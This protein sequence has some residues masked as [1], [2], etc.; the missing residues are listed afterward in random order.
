M[1]TSLDK[2]PRTEEHPSADELA[3]FAQGR[4]GPEAM[5]SVERHVATC[6][7][8]CEQLAAVPDDTLI[9]LAREAATHGVRSADTQATARPKADPRAIPPELADHP[10]Y[11]VLGL[12]GLGGMGA[13]YKAQHRL[14]ERLVALKVISPKLLA[15]PKALERFR[16]EFRAVAKLS[17]PNV[18]AAHDADQAGDLHFLVMEFVEGLSLDRLVAQTGQLQPAQACNL[19]KQAALGLAH[20]HERGLVHRDI[21]PQNLMVTRRGQLKILDCGLARIASH[22]ADEPAGENAAPRQSDATAEGTILGTPDYI[23]PEQIANP[24][25]ADIRA[26]IYSLGCTLYF[27]LTGQTLFPKGTA[28]DKLA[29]HAREAPRPIAELR[30]GVPTE[31]VRVLDRMLA[32]NPAERFQTPAEVAKALA[33]LAKG[34][35]AEPLS[36][37]VNPI[38]GKISTAPTRDMPALDAGTPVIPLPA[39]D[40]FA[41]LPP[42]TAPVIAPVNRKSSSWLDKFDQHFASLRSVTGIRLAAFLVALPLIAGL[43]AVPLAFTFLPSPDEND[44]ANVI[45]PPAP[46]SSA[47]ALPGNNSNGVFSPPAFPPAAVPPAAFPP[48]TSTTVASTLPRKVLLVVPSRGLW[49]PDYANVKF[50]FTKLGIPVK[51]ASTS[52]AKCGLHTESPAGTLYPEMRLDLVRSR[53]FG[54][55]VFAGFDTSEFHPDGEAGTVTRRLLQEFKDDGKLIASICVG[56]RVLAVH[57]LLHNT[58]AARSDYVD[59]SFGDC[60][61]IWQSQSVVRDGQII[62]AARDGDALRLAQEFEAA[63]GRPQ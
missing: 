45:K 4:L 62:T 16:R 5:H 1:R 13:V 35:N 50:A 51:T 30:A 46:P 33:P 21:K 14:M 27:L 24:R 32:K 2:L 3:A 7:S 63:L 28:M 20:M 57:G 38:G 34:Q 10:R 47:S 52:H 31:L 56:Q 6:D 54:A 17:H 55:I 36:V 9:H 18:V 11:Q 40:L 43:I 42:L 23:A 37:S 39:D 15:N 29:A 22:E 49:F 12:I 58:Q 48:A 44:S 59:A 53:D 26:D 60:R 25:A 19:I 61:A 41:A 8:C